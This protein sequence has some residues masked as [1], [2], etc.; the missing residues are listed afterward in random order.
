LTDHV[1][2]RSPRR[3]LRCDFMWPGGI[4]A[5]WC[6]GHSEGSTWAYES[7]GRASFCAMITSAVSSRRPERASFVCA[8]PRP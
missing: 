5:G 7:A 1:L 2:S 3:Q 6:E 8:A 4:G